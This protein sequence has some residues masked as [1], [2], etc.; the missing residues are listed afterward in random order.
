MS[1]EESTDMKLKIRMRDRRTGGDR[2]KCAVFVELNRRACDRRQGGD[3][4]SIENTR[5]GYQASAT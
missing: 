1:A 4:R 2:R 3:R 5:G